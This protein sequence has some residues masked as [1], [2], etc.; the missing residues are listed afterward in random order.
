MSRAWL[1]AAAVALVLSGCATIDRVSGSGAMQIDVEVY[2]GPLA[3]DPWTQWGEL[4][5]AVREAKTAA[6]AAAGYAQRVFKDLECVPREYLPG[7][8]YQPSP[9]SARKPLPAE[10][11]KKAV[12]RAMEEH[13]QSLGWFCAVPLPLKPQP[14]GRL[15]ECES[16][17]GVLCSAQAIQYADAM[18]AALDAKLRGEKIHGGPATLDDL[19]VNVR[20]AL[21]EVARV[22]TQMRG[23]AFFLTAAQLGSPLEHRRSRTALTNMA[24]ALSEYSNQ[25]ATRADA[26]L[27]QMAGPDGPDR[28]ELPLSLLLR[29][30]NPTDFLNLYIWNRAAAP[31]LLAEMVLQFPRAFTSEE[32]VD[33][34]R[35]YERLFADYNWSNVNSVYA[36]GQGDVTMAFIKDDIGN[37]NLKNFDNDP[38]E[39]LKSYTDVGKAALAEA[40]K[41]LGTASGPGAGAQAAAQL[42]DLANRIAVGR[43][44][45]AQ[46]TIGGLDV[47]A[48]HERVG[49]E[50]VG[51]KARAAA[52]ASALN[53]AITANEAKTADLGRQK[54][55]AQAALDAARTEREAIPPAT[56][57]EASDF[58]RAAERNR[59]DVFQLDQQLALLRHQIAT[60]VA[61]AEGGEPPEDRLARLEAERRPVEALRIENL[62][63][64]KATRQRV[65]RAAELDAAVLE[66]GTRVRAVEDGLASVTK[67]SERK[68]AELAGQ[69]RAMAKTARE[70]LER[71]RAIVELLQD[72]VA[73]APAGGG[74]AAPSSTIPANAGD[75]VRGLL[76]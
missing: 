8:E 31:A 44:A 52:E 45:A 32:T 26:L 16:L 42:T 1:G 60:G 24:V 62:E 3:Q 48:L 54:A 15:Q 27:Q 70:L 63:K 55:S 50:I 11:F 61:E 51:L 20:Q 58:E 67:D 76:R 40:V 38:R 43:T 14:A 47:T 34:V 23:T 28:R 13:G 25:I 12:D 21:G 22:A 64:A 6:W 4:L 35:G 2:K 71:H 65:R 57:E 7:K 36:S 9:D 30:T 59:Q 69:P 10:D 37:W 29:N 41:A 74:S 19:R 56:T 17:G 72:G 68:R 66:H 73:T 46:P 33:R 18:L 39:L 53:A 75:A 5:G 49:R